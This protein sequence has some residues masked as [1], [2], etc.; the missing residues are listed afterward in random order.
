MG[1]RPISALNNM[2]KGI[3][4]L[5]F[6]YCRSVWGAFGTTR[7]NKIQKLQNRAARIVTQ[8]TL[9]SS[10]APL[11]QELG[12][13][14]IGKLIYR[15]MSSMAYKCLNRLAPEYL[16]GCFSKLSDYH[17]R[18]LRT[19]KIDLLISRMKT[20]IV[21]QSFAYWGAK[22]WINLDS[23]AKSAPWIHCFKLKMKASK[24]L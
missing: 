13:S 12:W 3:V 10:A 24:V 2:Y 6:N 19:C 20:S 7:Q 17:T 9:D 21:Q 11:I 14:S 1:S 16:S 8:S 18:V 22:V 23:A 15:E 5:H 4:E